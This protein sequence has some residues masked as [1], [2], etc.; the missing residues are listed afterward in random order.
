MVEKEAGVDMTKPHQTLSELVAEQPG[1][2]RILD[3][4]GLDYCCHGT[5]SVHDACASAGIEVDD[6]V[7]AL[8]A[9]E[10]TGDDH[11][12]AAMSTGDLIAHLLE[13]HHVYLH[14]ELPELVRLAD[15]VRHVHG[16]LHPELER[17]HTLVCEIAADLEPHMLKEERVLFPSIMQL[18]N[19]P[20]SFPFGSIRNPIAMMTIEH[21]RAGQ[22]L[23]ELRAVTDAYSV[24]YDGCASYWLLYERL[25]ELEHDTHV[26][27]FEENHLLFPRVLAHEAAGT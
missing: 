21:E 22:L 27:V 6:V 12:C 8:G 4:I 13:T 7:A 5:D 16:E 10:R 18:G 11:D 20:V 1:S 17:V 25:A 19:G 15:K 3:R 14:G 23:A 24:P 26:H 9:C 2:A